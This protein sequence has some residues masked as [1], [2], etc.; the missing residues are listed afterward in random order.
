MPK[1]HKV[2]VS[3]NHY[4]KMCSIVGEDDQWI[5][6]VI[7]IHMDNVDFV[8]SELSLARERHKEWL[9]KEQ[10]HR[11]FVAELSSEAAMGRRINAIKVIRNHC[12][13]DL[14]TAKDIVE[15][16]MSAK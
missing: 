13:I 10:K 11:A 3:T 6:T 9:D 7:N 1:L 4:D 14:R 12:G 8:I 16:L 2:S 15:T 5:K